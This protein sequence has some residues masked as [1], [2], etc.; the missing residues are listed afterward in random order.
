MKYKSC[1]LLYYTV[2]GLVHIIFTLKCSYRSWG[3]LQKKGSSI[4]EVVQ[5]PHAAQEEDAYNLT[6][7][8]QLFH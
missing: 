1:W 4:K 6:K 8:F 7:F 2:I 3:V 5:S